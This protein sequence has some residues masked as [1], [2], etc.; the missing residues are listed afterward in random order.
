MG[1]R[2]EKNNRPAIIDR[3]KIIGKYHVKNYKQRNKK[4]RNIIKELIYN[5]FQPGKCMMI[6]LT[7]RNKQNNED[8]TQDDNINDTITEIDDTE[9]YL[10]SSF[11]F[12][13]FRSA[14]YFYSMPF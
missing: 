2:G 9:E 8:T 13:P 5:N 7:F 11:D 3:Q 14:H 10:F 4:R 12:I 6:T 1:F